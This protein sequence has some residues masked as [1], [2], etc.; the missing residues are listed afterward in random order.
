MTASTASLLE[1]AL[2]DVAGPAALPTSITIDYGA[3]AHEAALAAPAAR[4]W[5]ERSTRSLV[6]VQAEVRAADGALV[7]AASAVFRRVTAS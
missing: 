5:V 7:A 4:A 3:L 2:R 1:T 6:F